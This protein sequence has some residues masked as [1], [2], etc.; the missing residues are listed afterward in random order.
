[1]YSDGWFYQGY[2]DDA[3]RSAEIPPTIVVFVDVHEGI[4]FLNSPVFGNWE[5][6]MVSE[7]I[8][9][10][11]R[12]YRTIP[13]PLARGLIG[14]SVRGYSALMLPVLHPGVWGSVGGNDPWLLGMW[15]FTRSS[16]LA[17]SGLRGLP[18]DLD[19]YALL[20]FF[21]GAMLQLGAA[22]SPN[23]EAPLLCDFPVT[24]DGQWIPEI[25]EKWGAYDLSD[26]EILAKHSETLQGLLSIVIIII[27]VAN[28]PVNI[29]F[30]GQLQA[31]GIEVTR[32][33]MPG[34][35]SYQ[36]GERLI[37]LAKQILGAMVGAEV[38]VSPS[39]KVAALWGEIRQ[40]W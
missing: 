22:F 25:R 9:F 24:P 18:E 40:G 11:D 33:D 23:P 32:L 31:A 20:G 30:I 10:I 12:E 35:H 39:S 15:A 28:G 36:E 27:P 7:L 1:M 8:P 6:F 16:D 13:D 14:F 3:I 37:A 4:V 38:S 17:L 34:H 21:A 5:D 2:L 19:D 29:P 26:P